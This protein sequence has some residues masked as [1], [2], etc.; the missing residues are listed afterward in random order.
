MNL[1]LKYSL[2]FL[3]LTVIIAIILLF[4]ENFEVLYA[5]LISLAL[6][7]ILSILFLRKEVTE[8]LNDYIVLSQKIIHTEEDTGEK[9]NFENKIKELNN[10]TFLIENH[11]KQNNSSREITG[12][13]ESLSG[14][15]RRLATEL[16]TAK[17]FKV[18]RNEF[19]GNVA[20][21]MRTP[22][23]AI[24]LS[25]ETLLDG[26]IDDKKVNIDFLNRAMNQTGRL[27]ELV[28]DLI[29]ISRIETGMKMSKRYF[30]LNDFVANI[31]NELK[32]LVEKKNISITHELLVAPDTEVFGD[33][34]RLKQVFINLVE[35]SI[36]YT[37]ENGSIKIISSNGT[38]KEVK[39]SIEDTGIGIPKKDIPRIFERFY[40]VDKNRS[41]DLGGSGLGLSIVKHIL[42]AHG[43][44]INVE[45]EVDK[46]SK[47][48]FNL[49]K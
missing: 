29:S 45:S 48:S 49:K 16:D 34:E 18:N 17:V 6:A 31:I 4:Q 8:N 42:E 36:K 28:D 46:G 44:Q 22:I 21:E 3:S 38:D 40:R 15:V 2:F 33:A 24:Q 10:I 19:L 43:S 20:H 25:I 12:I 23:F 14:I 11:I 47:F 13:Y 32:A 39:I 26:A 9:N 5:A 41:R 35:N 1:L 30:T 7:Y 27:K 37:P